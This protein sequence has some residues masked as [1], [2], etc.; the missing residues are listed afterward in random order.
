MAHNSIIAMMLVDVNGCPVTVSMAVNCIPTWHSCEPTYGNVICHADASTC[1]YIVA[2]KAGYV[3]GTDTVPIAPS[4]F[5]VTGVLAIV[6]VALEMSSISSRISVGMTGVFVWSTNCRSKKMS[7]FGYA[8][9]FANGSML[10]PWRYLFPICG[11]MLLQV[12]SQRQQ[13]LDAIA[14]GA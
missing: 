8:L 11:M 1:M 9:T 10:V 6:T 12:K 2:A 3:N 4:G 5:S 7:V 14:G 13:A